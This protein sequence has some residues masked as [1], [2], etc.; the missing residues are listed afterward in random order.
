MV[1]KWKKFFIVVM[2]ANLFLHMTND[3]AWKDKWGSIFGKFK[4]FD[5]MLE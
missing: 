5:H 2:N 3:L 4:I 1:T